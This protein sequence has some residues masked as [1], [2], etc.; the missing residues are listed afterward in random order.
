MST[1]VEVPQLPETQGGGSSVRSKQSCIGSIVPGDAASIG[2]SLIHDGV[3]HAQEHWRL[4]VF[5]QLLSLALAVGSA[6]YSLIHLECSLKIP[7]FT[8]GIFYSIMAFA[9]IP[10][11]IRNRRAAKN[12]KKVDTEQSPNEKDGAGTG[13]LSGTDENMAK[14]HHQS[15]N[16]TPAQYSFLGILPLHVPAW[17]YFLMA[18][19]DVEALFLLILALEYTTIPSVLLFMALAVPSAM[20]LSFFYLNRKYVPVHL[21]GVAICLFGV[22]VNVLS[23]IESNREAAAA[24]EQQ[25][26]QNRGFKTKANVVVVDDSELDD[27]ADEFPYKSFGDTLAIIGAIASGASDFLLEHT[28][29]NQ[30][31]GQQ[32][33]V[34][35]MYG[36]FGAFISFFQSAIM[37]ADDVAALFRFQGAKPSSP[38]GVTGVCSME[39]GLMLVMIFAVPTALK[40]IG[41][42]G[43]LNYSEAALLNLHYLTSNL[44]SVLF[45]IMAEQIMPRPM[46]YVSLVLII[47]GLFVY[48][49]GPTPIADEKA[50]LIDMQISVLSN[51]MIDTQELHDNDDDSDQVES[52][53]H[54]RPAAKR[55]IAS[56]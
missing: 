43:F 20:I 11:G 40:F 21:I 47:V 45:S 30:G 55:N 44:W 33:E 49:S 8:N 15:E 35:A 4:L 46:F 23:D 18:L 56:A 48:E 42:V 1:Q 13:G 12:S 52:T 2:A 29:N 41:V 38:E 22:A 25:Q 34:I 17:K 14:Q 19:L 10:L 6:S 3:A 36:L 32:L 53:I 5:A 24:L 26:Q 16:T 9:L 54:T 51:L 28:L 31:K 50:K 7:N 39:F 37:E 27:G